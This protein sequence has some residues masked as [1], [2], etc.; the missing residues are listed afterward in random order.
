MGKDCKAGWT[1]LQDYRQA[2]ANQALWDAG[3]DRAFV[4]WEWKGHTG[5]S[6]A[7]WY[8][9]LGDIS[10][11]HPQRKET[12]AFPITSPT[13][14]GGFRFKTPAHATMLKHEMETV[15]PDASMNPWKE[16]AQKAIADYERIAAP[17]G[18]ERWS[19]GMLFV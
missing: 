10:N 9:T 18:S 6:G 3:V 2:K 4:F 16:Q 7:L 17:L 13:K 15:P 5:E 11:E 8:I 1:E 12:L 19:S 14:P